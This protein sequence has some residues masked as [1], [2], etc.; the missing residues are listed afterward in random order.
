MNIR[1]DHRTCYR[2]DGEVSYSIQDIRLT[3]VD[4]AGQHVLAWTVESN[5]A[6]P[7]T[8]GR[9]AYGNI[10]LTLAT[11][12]PHED[13][14]I[15]AR[16][17]VVTR[18]TSGV[19]RESDEPMPSGVFLR[20]TV[21]TAPDDGLRALAA[22]LADVARNDPLDAAYR[23]MSLVRAAIDYRT[24]ITH[25]ATTAAEAL[26]HGHGVCQDHAHVFIACA[27]LLGLPARYV[28]GYL[29]AGQGREGGGEGPYEASHAWAEALIPDLGWVGFDVANDIGLTEAHVRVAAGLDYGDVPPVRGARRGGASDAL[30]V[31]V[32]VTQTAASQQ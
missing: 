5:H 1:I 17:R 16:G 7:M 10:V 4:H 28:S 25:V 20:D 24:E 12:E 21:L 13:L 18:D 22:P 3:P 15:T 32:T 11:T 31:S 19:L 26:A 14:I 27:R 8:R 29:W 30:E 23:L 9:D 2:Y 6:A